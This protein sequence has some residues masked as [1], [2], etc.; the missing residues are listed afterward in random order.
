M[1]VVSDLIPKG[2]LPECQT[3]ADNAFITPMATRLYFGLQLAV[4]AVNFQLFRR[5]RKEAENFRR[6]STGI[7]WIIKK[8]RVPKKASVSGAMT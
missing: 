1:K 5:F 2:K 4:A 8:Q 3:H 6:S 7:H